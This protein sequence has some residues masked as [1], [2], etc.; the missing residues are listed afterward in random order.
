MAIRQNPKPA[1]LL[2]A[3]AARRAGAFSILLAL[4]SI[5]AIVAY[6]VSV[7]GG[8][9]L[10]TG[11]GLGKV[12]LLAAM[13]AA[14]VQ[15]I[16]QRSWAQR[17]LLIVWLAALIGA[18]ALAVA[19]LLWGKPAWWGI[20]WPPAAVLPG[21]VVLEVLAVMLL[22]R[23]SAEGSRLRY[24]T[25]VAISIAAAM[26]LVIVV[27]MLSQKD[28][29]RADVE[30]LRRFS[31][32]DRT[33]KILSS[34]DT[35]ITLTCVYTSSDEKS[36]TPLRRARV[37]ELLNEM[38]EHNPKVTVVNV[39]GDVEKLALVGRLRKRREQQA[40]KHIQVLESFQKE[41]VRLSNLLETQQKRWR[42][43][44]GKSYLD[45]WGLTADVVR[46][47][48]DSG[49]SLARQAEVV[50]G[51]LAGPGLVDYEKLTDEVKETLSRAD[52]ALAQIASRMKQIGKV[53]AAVEANRNEALKRAD[54]GAAAVK[55]MADA[56]GK[57]GA[58]P[59]ADPAAVLKAFSRA[60]EE[61][62]K[63]IAL[64]ARSLDEIAGKE[65]SAF[66][67][68]SQAWMVKTKDARRLV[69]SDGIV[70]SLGRE[71]VTD[72]YVN[73]LKRTG[74]IA[75]LKLTAE[76]YLRE[77][78]TDSQV[79]MINKLRK[80]VAALAA[81]LAVARS[82][83]EAGIERLAKV[84][85][86]TRALMTE[87][88]EKAFEG[89]RK[90]IAGLLARIDGLP[91][92]QADTLADEITGEN[93]V[94]V[95]AG[96]KSEV[97][98]FESVWPLKVQ[99]FGMG[100]EG[101]QER[102]F[103]G[104]SAISSKILSLTH[105]P[106]ATVVITYFRPEVPPQMQMRRFAP[107]LPLSPVQLTTLKRRLEEANFEV[108]EWNLT[109]EMPEL[110][111]GR[112]AAML[113]LPP[114]VS[115]MGVFGPQGPPPFGPQQLRKIT[116]AIDSGT[117]AIFL[118]V[119]LPEVPV[120]PEMADYLRD[121]WGIEPKTDH[122][123]IPAV[124]DSTRPDKFKIAPERFTHLSL[125][126]FSDHPIGKPLQ[127][128]RVLW[129]YLC[130]VLTSASVPKGVKVAPLLSVPPSWRDTW[131]TARPGR[132]LNALLSNRESYVA[133]APGDLRAPFDLAVAATRQAGKKFQ[134]S[135]IVVL[136][137]GASLSDGYMDQRIP[138]MAPDKTI[139]FLDPPRANADLVI[140][141]VYWLI[142]RQRFIAKGPAQ[143]QPIAMMS[144]LTRR[145]LWVLCVV[146]LPLVVLA[147]GV[148]VLVVR[149]M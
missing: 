77:A 83:A 108:V 25:Y 8:P 141:S 3:P 52:T 138:Q 2:D 41:A 63:Q 13:A 146:G 99:Q 27:N 65:Y 31:L 32:S 123:V 29:F 53:P 35:P 9:P 93:I 55:A 24:G 120:G 96:G 104:D 133:P 68:A 94:I 91:K 46:L 22:L 88:G 97:V 121:N 54:A 1:Q 105:E 118:F 89:I 127:A 124:A 78:K 122:I 142:G 66:I 69:T 144:D 107:R 84:D 143:V 136:G 73:A 28:Y 36:Q 49:Q 106:F 30:T 61:A 132:F 76:T 75:E 86:P 16:R 81:S 38:R 110:P 135:R 115:A 45:L 74:G 111:E 60:A 37:L 47:L 102:V 59:P 92:L 15:L 23:A 6:L 26:A 21:A 113:V 100:A 103:N 39:A 58:E 139:T 18:A 20:S 56:L 79:R 95:E 33:K 126:N 43:I 148:I 134:A 80:D 17:F 114:P 130:P 85:P 19:V 50:K 40:G 129:S 119:P 34:V 87:A 51:K 70:F 57:K 147:A 98:D 12:A 101:T 42:S 116:D 67:A 131:A 149:R 5:A 44:S 117:P 125:S 90:P 64:T 112:Q 109:E 62:A 145:S 11:L 72:L 71:T 14:G 140:N 7:K 128:Q 48:S 4:L 137:M 10:L 82:A